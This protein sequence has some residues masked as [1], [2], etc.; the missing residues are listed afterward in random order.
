[1]KIILFKKTSKKSGTVLHV[2][3]SLM[4]DLTE[5]RQICACFWI[6]FVW[7]VILVEV[8]EKKPSFTKT[9]LVEKGRYFNSLLKNL[10]IFFLDFMLST[11]GSFFKISCDVES[12][13]ILMGVS[14]PSESCGV[15]RTLTISP[16]HTRSVAS[17]TALSESASAQSYADLPLYTSTG[18]DC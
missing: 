11:S 6:R 9:S 18:P 12:E 10:W 1:M 2:C 3:V 13:T 17:F 7:Y 4:S 14:V 8:H 16:A 5:D 15:P